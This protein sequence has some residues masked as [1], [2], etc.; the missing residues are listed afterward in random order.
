[1]PK[2]MKKVNFQVLVCDRYISVDWPSPCLCSGLLAVPKWS[3]PT[4]YLLYLAR[5]VDPTFAWEWLFFDGE[6]QKWRFAGFDSYRVCQIRPSQVRMRYSMVPHT[7]SRYEKS[8][9]SPRCFTSNFARQNFGDFPAIFGQN[10]RF[11]VSMDVRL[12]NLAR[13]KCCPRETI[14]NGEYLLSFITALYL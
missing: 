8:T 13:H 3:A 1:M 14:T 5:L 6:R 9:V 12:G 10:W 11:R 2:I 4:R 7:N